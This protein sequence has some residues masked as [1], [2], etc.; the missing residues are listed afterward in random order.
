MRPLRLL[1]P[2]LGPL[3][4]GCQQQ[5][6]QDP[7][8][9]RDTWKL[10]PEGFGAND[11]NLRA[12]VANPPDLVA[13]TNEE[14]TSVAP[15]AAR[16]VRNLFAGKRAILAGGATTQIGGQGQQQQQGAAGTAGGAAGNGDQ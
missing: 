16:P 7:F 11:A 8:D 3:L 2:I 12:M 14:D 6:Q 15:L 9:R 1:L 5:S 10:A 13:G 4:A